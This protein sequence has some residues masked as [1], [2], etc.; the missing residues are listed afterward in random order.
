MV[1][2]ARDAYIC[3]YTLVTFDRARRQQTNVADADAEHAPMGPGDQDAK[4]PDRGQP[5]LRGA[6]CGHLVHPRVAG[7]ICRALGVQNARQ[8]KP[9]IMKT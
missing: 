9:L 4:L 1:E 7:C 6:Q 5:F 2:I 3:G 8:G